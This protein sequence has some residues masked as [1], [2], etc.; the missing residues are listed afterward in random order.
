M[1]G[2]LALTI[3]LISSVSF[4]SASP[5]VTRLTMT[6]DTYYDLFDP[7]ELEVTLENESPVRVTLRHNRTFEKVFTFTAKKQDQYVSTYAQILEDFLKQKAR[8]GKLLAFNSNYSYNF[9]HVNSVKEFK[10][11]FS[12]TAAFRDADELFKVVNIIQQSIGEAL[13][14]KGM[15]EQVYLTN[16]DLKEVE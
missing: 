8:A 15:P 2:L 12:R 14:E 6:M 9:F 3:L 5:H 11:R 13:L 1:R 10:S 7:A 16:D 4:A